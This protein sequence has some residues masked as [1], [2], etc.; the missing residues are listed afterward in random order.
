M[1]QETQNTL[2]S[3]FTLDVLMQLYGIM[4]DNANNMSDGTF[5]QLLTLAEYIRDERERIKPFDTPPVA[6]PAAAQAADG[7][8]GSEY[9]V[10]VSEVDGS[11]FIKRFV[12]NVPV[13][14]IGGRWAK[15][16][17]A[18]TEADRLNAENGNAGGGV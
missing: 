14:Q 9:R 10:V 7:G 1:S 15:E 18:Q 13:E 5:Q 8:T 6:A 3:E 11:C 17:D 4:R 2:Y 16:R 12:G